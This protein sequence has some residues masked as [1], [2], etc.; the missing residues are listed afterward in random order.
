M[1]ESEREEARFLFP[2]QWKYGKYDSM[3]NDLGGCI[4]LQ[5]A[6]NAIYTLTARI[7]NILI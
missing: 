7:A 4:V 1:L 5:S 2:L 6:L 3:N